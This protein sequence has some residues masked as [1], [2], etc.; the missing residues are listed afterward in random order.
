MGPEWA[1]ALLVWMCVLAGAALGAALRHVLPAEHMG[2]PSRQIV[3]VAIGLVATLSALVLG[4]LVASAKS[5]FDARNE[6]IKQS[7]TRLVELDRL[8]RQYG[9]DAAEARKRLRELTEHRIEHTWGT[10]A[11]DPAP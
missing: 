5:G 8:L 9:P 3:N 1:I 6:E 4:L 2:E 10:P 7:G 11:D